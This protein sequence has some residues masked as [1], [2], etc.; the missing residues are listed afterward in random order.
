MYLF[1]LNILYIYI[2]RIGL[3]LTINREKKNTFKDGNNNSAF[4]NLFVNFWKV[5]SNSKYCLSCHKLIK[6]ILICENI[7]H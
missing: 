4:H 5:I 2:F 3:K 7:V 6:V 1:S